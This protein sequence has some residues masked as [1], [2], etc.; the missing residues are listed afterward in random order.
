MEVVQAACAGLSCMDRRVDAVG[1]ML[2]HADSA[3]KAVSLAEKRLNRLGCSCE[4]HDLFAFF[5]LLQLQ[6]SSE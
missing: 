5:R 1:K 3:V 2:L 6:L 4:A